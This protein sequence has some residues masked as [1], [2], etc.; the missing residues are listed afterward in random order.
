ML[1]DIYNIFFPAKPLITVNRNLPINYFK[2]LQYHEEIKSKGYVV[3]KNVVTDKNISFLQDVFDKLQKFPEYSIDD[4][5]QNSGRY[6]SSEIRNFVMENIGAFSKQFLS[7]IF[8]EAL[9]DTNT[10]GAF[11]IKPPSKVSELNP[12][13]DAPVID[14]MN[15]NALFVWIPLCDITEQNGA[16]YVL[17]KSHLFGNYQRSLNVPWMFEKHTK[18]LWKHMIPVYLEK[19]DILCWDSALIHASSPNLS[20]KMRIAITTTILPKDFKMVE[21]FKDKNTPND[22]VERYEVE[23]SFWENDDIMK[24]PTCPPNKFIG[25]EKLVYN[26]TISKSALI[27]LI[28]K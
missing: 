19:G 3:I 21:F 22:S 26:N 25:Y 20:D 23:R 17:P 13:Q 9:Y 10:T 18:M 28:R 7:Q 6:R 11:Q 4:K 14:E 24:R 1:K 8:N 27:D 16:V 5:F 2:E 12:H 15:Y